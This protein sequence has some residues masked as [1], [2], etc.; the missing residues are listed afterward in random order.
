MQ[1]LMTFIEDSPLGLV[2]CSALLALGFWLLAKGGD[3]LVSGG[4]GLAKQL[5]IKT[6]VVGLTIIAFSTSAPELAFNVFAASSGHGEITIG[7][8]F[9]SNIANLTLVLGVGALVHNK[10]RKKDDGQKGTPISKDFL[11][12]EGQWLI[13]ATFGIALFTAITLLAGNKV[14]SSFKFNWFWG[15]IFLL[16]FVLFFWHVIVKH[17][18]KDNKREQVN[19]D[20]NNCSLSK[21]ILFLVGGLLLL[22]LGG[23]SAEIGSVVGARIIGISDMF[24]GATIVAIATSLPELVTTIIAAKRDEAD[25]IWGNIVGSNLF[26]ILFVLPI[27]LIVSA[28]VGIEYIEIPETYEPWVY[29][30][31]M[32][33]VTVLSWKFMKNDEDITNTEGGSLV[34]IYVVFLILALI[35]KSALT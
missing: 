33:L 5:N 21:A 1:E 28:I 26:N 8:I 12:K 30:A 7:N 31:V 22:T 18:N 20:K 19:G 3:Y 13:Y 24:I 23:K 34:G 17:E 14:E 35:L 9:G 6:M 11:I 32:F 15:S 27:T 25:L 16:S 29:M 2:I 4:L 10:V